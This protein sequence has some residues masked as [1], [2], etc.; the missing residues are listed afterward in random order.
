MVLGI[1]GV[2]LGTFW[3]CWVLRDTGWLCEVMG[4]TQLQYIGT[5][6]YPAVLRGSGG[7][8]VGGNKKYWSA[9]LWGNVGYWGY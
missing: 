5:P 1:L 3:Y 9:M 4:G 7:Y 6:L 8:R 2:L